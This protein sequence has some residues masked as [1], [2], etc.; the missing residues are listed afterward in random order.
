MPN[1]F[2]CRP[3]SVALTVNADREPAYRS[4]SIAQNGFGGEIDMVQY[5]TRASESSYPESD[6]LIVLA[7]F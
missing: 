3:T 7:A 2:H 5:F 6:K 4:K 1:K